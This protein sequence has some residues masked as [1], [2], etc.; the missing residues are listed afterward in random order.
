MRSCL[1]GGR[2]S[3]FVAN[4]RREELMDGPQRDPYTRRVSEFP[5]V[6]PGRSGPPIGT[7]AVLVLPAFRIGVAGSGAD[8]PSWRINSTLARPA[9]PVSSSPHRCMT[10]QG[11][12]PCTAT[13]CPLAQSRKTGGPNQHPG[14]IAAG[15]A[16]RLQES[17]QRVGEVRRGGWDTH[18]DLRW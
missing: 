12:D 2:R 8:I 4:P 3:A 14:I 9:F 6:T 15:R 5:D 17:A 7:S 13:L 18:V 16:G 10:S 1:V 11:H